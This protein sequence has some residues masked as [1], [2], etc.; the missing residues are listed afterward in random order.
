MQFNELYDKLL[1]GQ[2]VRIVNTETGGHLFFGELSYL[3]HS[4]YEKICLADVEK[5]YVFVEKDFNSYLVVEV[6]VE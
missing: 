4:I 3:P 2:R 5:V 1:Q 6:F